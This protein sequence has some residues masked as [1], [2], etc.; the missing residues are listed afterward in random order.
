MPSGVAGRDLGTTFN[1][2]LPIRFV[3][4]TLALT[5]NQTNDRDNDLDEGM[6]A[7]RDWGMWRAVRG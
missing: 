7:G 6:E 4:P 5:T 3:P 1:L 2:W